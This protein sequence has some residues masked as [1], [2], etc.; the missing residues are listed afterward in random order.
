MPALNKSLTVL[1][2]Y[3]TVKLNSLQVKVL[4]YLPIADKIDIV[5]IALQKSEQ[6][7]IYNELLLDMYFHLHIIMCYTDLEFSDEDL[8]DLMN[9]YD[10]LESHGFINEIIQ[11]MDQDEYKNLTDYL[12]IMKE[13][14]LKYNNTAAAVLSRI[15]Q[16]LPKNAEAAKEILE[17]FD[18]EKYQEA[19]NF[20]TALNGGRP[21]NT[22][23]VP[24]NPAALSIKEENPQLNTTD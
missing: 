15:V 20:A 8:S 5:Q 21:I 13:E 3:K 6:N 7:G 23:T 4:Q 17:G 1:K 2:E 18:L 14:N 16:D 12:S 22:Q 11:A 19:A 10:R 9:L 24:I